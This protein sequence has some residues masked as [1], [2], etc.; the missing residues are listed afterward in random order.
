MT[1]KAQ[2]AAKGAMSDM[3][4]SLE[5]KLNR[6]G[7]PITMLRNSQIGPYVFPDRS[8]YTNWREEQESWASATPV[9]GSSV[10]MP[11][12]YGPSKGRTTPGWTIG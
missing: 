9:P 11:S 4:E 2:Q 10:A 8:E 5:E 6:V 3:S 7:D 12:G 1:K